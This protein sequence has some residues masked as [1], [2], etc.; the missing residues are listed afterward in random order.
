MAPD[1][2]EEDVPIGCPSSSLA[3]GFVGRLDDLMDHPSFCA[4]DE[5]TTKFD[6]YVKKP[7][8][9]VFGTTDAKPLSI[10]SIWEVK[11]PGRNDGA[12]F[13]LLVWAT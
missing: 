5:S 2:V 1:K 9:V 11:A 10:H 13:V 3:D 4:S 7:D 12:H 6:D 8:F